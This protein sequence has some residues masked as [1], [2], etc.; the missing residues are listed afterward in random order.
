MPLKVKIRTRS[1]TEIG[2]LLERYGERAE[3]AVAV[4]LY[5]EAEGIM[6]QSKELVPVDTGALRASG[7]VGLPERAGGTIRVVLGYGGPAAPYA[8][9]VHEDLEAFH[10]DGQAKY[11]EMPIRQATAG[12][13]Q[14]IVAGMRRRLGGVS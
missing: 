12:M 4:E 9:K 11:L 13:V 1:G 2:R 5:Q 3:K 6:A 14:R 7:H 8:F 10:D